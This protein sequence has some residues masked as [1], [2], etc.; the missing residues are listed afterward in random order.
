MSE[1]TANTYASAYAAI[2]DSL[3]NAEFRR[4]RRAHLQQAVESTGREYPTLC[5]ILVVIRGIYKYAIRN[6]IVD[7]D[8]SQYLDISKFKPEE[9]GDPVHKVF[10]AAEM[11]TLWER[12][13]DP[14]VQEILMLCY[15]GL[16]IAEYLAL[17]PEDIDIPNRILTVRKSKTKSGVRRVP[18]AEKT[19]AMWEELRERRKTP[20]ERKPKQQYDKFADTM[21]A[22][23]E[24]IGIDRHL[25]H[26]TRHTCASMLQDRKVDLLVIKRILGH[27]VGDMT[28]R[29]YIDLTDAALR[30][31]IN[32]L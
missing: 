23:T 29:V 2:A 14:F 28:E 3:G 25:P 19:A 1:S 32:R 6:D 21:T 30:E 24:K 4:L 8:H 26:D 20:D 5:M 17:T 22:K 9:A 13:D 7:R 16:R 11:K 10:T 18:I 15:S 12:A 31:A 27:R